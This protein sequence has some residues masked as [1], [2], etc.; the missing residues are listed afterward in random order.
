MTREGKEEIE[1]LHCTIISDEEYHV[2]AGL[3]EDSVYVKADQVASSRASGAITEAKGTR[4]IF[5]SISTSFRSLIIPPF[6]RTRRSDMAPAPFSL[7]GSLSEFDSRDETPVIGTVFLDS[8]VQLTDILTRLDSDSLIRD[9]A[10]LISH[11]GVVFFKNQELT[12]KHLKELG[13]RLGELS[14]KPKSSTLHKHPV[15]ENLPELGADI[16]II[17]SES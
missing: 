4:L 17:S 7:L 12:P 3:L 10:T 13:Q 16:S 8:H 2:V 14:G 5:S 6:S 15:S 1:R 9:L 11:R